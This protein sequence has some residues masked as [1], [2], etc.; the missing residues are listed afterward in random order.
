MLNLAE[1]E[2]FVAFAE[3][4]TLSRVA[5]QLHISQPTITRTMRH[6]EEAFG[7][8]LFQR[9][10]NRIELNETG[11]LAAE[12]ARK[13]LFEAEKATH[14]VQA[15]EQSLR[16]LTVHSCAPAPLWSLLPSLSQ[17]HPENTVSSKIA[18]IDGILH[19]VLSGHCDIG[20]LPFP[21]P[22]EELTDVPFVREK[23]SVCVP[24]DSELAMEP[25][26]SFQ[27]LNGFNCLL[28]DQIGFWTDL[29]REKMPASRFLIQTDEFEFQELVRTS[30]LFCFITDLANPKNLV[31]PGRVVLP[32]TDP[33]AD[34][35]YHLI[36]QPRN[37]AHITSDL[38]VRK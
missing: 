4:G 16:T 7:A 37:M 6:V 10:K 32:I 34:V 2:Q 31:P 18:G 5:E 13:L 1:L 38:S 12:Y 23:L 33:E 20:I 27:Q 22:N 30:S 29:C 28:R 15:F 14:A 26:T 19:D 11:R 36:C 21:C 9:G 3:L 35:E 25:Q 8:S 24:K 17:K